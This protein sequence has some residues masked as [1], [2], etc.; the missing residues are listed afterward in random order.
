MLKRNKQ[1]LTR[2]L[3]VFNFLLFVTI[4]AVSAQQPTYYLNPD[5]K[6]YQYNLETWTTKEGLPTN[7]VLNL[8]QS[9]EGYLWISSYDG[10]IRFDGHKFYVFDK[11]NT[12]ELKSNTI[13]KIVQSKDST[14][15][16]TT[17]GSGLISYKDKCFRRYGEELG[18]NN[19][20]SVV[21]PDK[22]GRIWS[23]APGKGLFIL[24]GEE[25]TFVKLPDLSENDEIHAIVE[26]DK[27]VMWFGTLGKGLYSY[28]QGKVKNYNANDGLLN[29]WI[30]SLF[31]DRNGLLW[32]GTNSGLCFYDGDNFKKYDIPGIGSVNEITEDIYGN[33]WI[34]STTGLFRINYRTK[35]K[36]HLNAAKGLHHNFVND[37]MFD[38]EGNLWMAN[39]KGGISRLRD[40]KFINYSGIGGLHG[41]VVNAIC[42]L[43]TNKYLVAF[44][45]GRMSV[46]DN[47]NI[48][49][50]STKTRLEG[51]RIRH[52]LKDSKNNLWI[53]TYS[54][55]LKVSP[56]RKEI[57]YR[58]KNGLL[59]IAQIRLTYEDL[60][61][62]LWVGTKN[63]G[64]IRINQDNSLTVF[65]TSNGLS[66]NLIMSV[67]E[68]K[69]GEILVGTSEGNG[70]L[71]VISGDSV[72]AVYSTKEGLISDVVFNTYTDSSGI[73]WIASD[74][75]LCRF[76]D[77]NIK[78]FTKE[79]GLADDSPFDILED[80][81]GGLWLPCSKGLMKVDKHELI[82][83][84]E[85]ST[86]NISCVLYSQ[87]DG[88][89]QQ[90]CN[91]TAKTVKAS[92]GTLLFP[93]IDGIAQIDPEDIPTNNFVPPVI[94]EKLVVDEAEITYFDNVLIDKNS[95]RLTFHFT[96]LSLYEPHEV[97]FKYQ[98]EKFEDEWSQVKDMRSVSYTNLPP[99]NYEFKVIACNNDGLWNFKG[100]SLKFRIEPKFYERLWF[101]AFVF[102][103]ILAV[104]YLVYVFRIRTLKKRQ[105]ELEE[106]VK[107]R[108]V[109]VSVKNAQLERQK[110][111]I[112][113]QAGE[114]EK[115]KVQLNILNASKDK[116]FSIIAHDLRGPLGNF[117][118]ILDIFINDPEAYDEADK[119]ELLVMLSENSKSTYELLENLLNWSVSQQGI[120]SYKPEIFLVAPLLEEV[121][122][123]VMPMA[124]RKE[125]K[126]TSKILP[127][128]L[129]EADANMVR[130]IFRNLISNSVKF[131]GQNG[132]IRVYAITRG[133]RVEFSV[134][135][136]GEGMSEEL[137]DHLFDELNKTL[138]FGTNGKDGSGLGLILCKEFVEKNGGKIW[139][140]STL[141]K[142][143]TFHFTLKRP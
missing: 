67:E 11:F 114:L 80:R 40:G 22:K 71:N 105:S 98:L 27:G 14:L 134:K 35:E 16:I 60:K 54:G 126:I 5:K 78:C 132:D 39:Y 102:V 82:N 130:L 28:A 91:P 128:T 34:C 84:D 133:Q 7:S 94:I 10:L 113:M 37:I 49:L 21:Y 116:M 95:R 17:Q 36:E 124:K 62:R 18:L 88:M 38:Q 58:N 42:E 15:W 73:T 108:T 117:K 96:A 123:I 1:I 131:T 56:D 121:I 135:D 55:L 97:S 30:Y 83:R 9:K 44:D 47:G 90:E 111:E 31:V 106:K 86:K 43:D 29:N 93:T 64:L 74:G 112:I 129:V 57:W 69:S 12:P 50:F 137:K 48:N 75:G 103:F 26:D 33:L 23:A 46:I 118:T 4:V 143:S 81:F 6:L 92:D 119:E 125:I 13:K 109:E 136:N 122:S 139:V 141:G 51:K 20:Y 70:G 19:L 61:G 25:F 101:P 8:Q 76:K 52:L 100:A 120:I 89:H 127:D 24:E 63:Q 110:K 66:A 87:K 140:E 115:Q 32:I 99:G 59:P 107:S 41:K 65:N 79:D 3:Q 72:E 142:G 45:N 85:G 77:G 2:K 138:H 53:S 104:G 68:L